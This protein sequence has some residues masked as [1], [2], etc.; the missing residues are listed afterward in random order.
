MS[1]TSSFTNPDGILSRKTTQMGE[2]IGAPL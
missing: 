1:F 2:A